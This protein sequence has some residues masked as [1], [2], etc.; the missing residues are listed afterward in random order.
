MKRFASLVL[1]LVLFAAPTMVL[2][3]QAPCGRQQAAEW[4][5]P[6][7]EDTFDGYVD[8]ILFGE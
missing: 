6:A 3:H 8:T 1:A 5:G 4:N 7:L 2:A